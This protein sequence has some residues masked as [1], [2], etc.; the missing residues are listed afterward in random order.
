MIDGRSVYDGGGK[1]KKQW[2]R[3]IA[4]NTKINLS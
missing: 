3:L 2:L 4:G 1:K